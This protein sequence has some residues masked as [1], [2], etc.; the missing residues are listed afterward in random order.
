MIVGRWAPNTAG[1]TSTEGYIYMAKYRVYKE[2]ISLCMIVHTQFFYQSIE[3]CTWSDNGPGLPVL[4][5]L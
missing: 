3:A 2:C 1:S 4:A 5:R